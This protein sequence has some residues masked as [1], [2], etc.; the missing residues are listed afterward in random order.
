MADHV[1]ES[2]RHQHLQCTGHYVLCSVT[3]AGRGSTAR[4]WS[5]TPRVAMAA[6]RGISNIALWR[7]GTL[8]R[9]D[10]DPLPKQLAA[11]ARALDAG[12][13]SF[14]CGNCDSDWSVD[15]ICKDFVG[16]E[17]EMGNDRC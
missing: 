14:L 6:P 3:A 1:R 16:R 7:S 8:R 15:S 13:P 12:F 17:M 5:R 10:V 2:A 9:R 4:P 11:N